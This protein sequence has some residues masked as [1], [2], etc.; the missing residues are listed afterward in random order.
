M[1][2]YEYVGGTSRKF[3]EI[4]EVDE[5]GKNWIVRVRY[6]RIGKGAQTHTKIFSYETGAL[7]YRQEKILEKTRKGY[8]LK[9]PPKPK[10]QPTF[11]ETVPW[12]WKPPV[13]PVCQHVTITRN[14]N[15]YKCN[16]CGD[17]V[18]FDKPQVEVEQPEFQQRVR[19]YFAGASA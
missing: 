9:T 3:W 17:Q 14:G 4:E 6:G 15:K 18:E 16:A 13:K 11:V 8:V 1:K 19:R 5:Q 12:T 10:P 2:R 7:R